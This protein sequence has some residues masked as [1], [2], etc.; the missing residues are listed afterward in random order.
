MNHKYSIIAVPAL[1]V[2]AVVLAASES[3][4]GVPPEDP[5][6][7]TTVAPNNPGPPN[8]PNYDIRTST[9]T[10]TGSSSSADDTAVEILQAGAAAIGGAG[11]ALAGTWVY[12]RRQ[13]HTA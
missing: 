3:S 6:P 1:A 5:G 12:R 7:A 9:T 4:A 2:A 11:I 10:G 8:Y 13:T